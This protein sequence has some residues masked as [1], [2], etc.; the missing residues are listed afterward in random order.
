[1]SIGGSYFARILTYVLCGAPVAGALPLANDF[2]LWTGR[3]GD[4]PAGLTFVCVATLLGAAIVE[5][6]Q[7]LVA[8]AYTPVQSRAVRRRIE[9]EIDQLKAE[10]RPG[11]R[12]EPTSDSSWSD[13]HL[14]HIQLPSSFRTVLSLACCL[15]EAWE[16]VT[17][18][19]TRIAS[20]I[21]LH[22]L[23]VGAVVS[24]LAASALVGHGNLGFWAPVA[25]SIAFA[26]SFLMFGRVVTTYRITPRKPTGRTDLALLSERALDDFL[27]AKL[28]GLNAG[29]SDRVRSLEI[30]MGRFFADHQALVSHYMKVTEE[31]A[32]RIEALGLKVLR[33][34]DAGG[35]ASRTMAKLRAELAE[36]RE[37]SARV[38]RADELG[39]KALYEVS[40]LQRKTARISST[41]A[42]PTAASTEVSIDSPTDGHEARAGVDVLVYATGT[43]PGKPE[44]RALS[45]ALKKWLAE[46][47]VTIQLPGQESEGSFFGRWIARITGVYTKEELDRRLQQGFENLLSAAQ[48]SKVE[49]PMSEN[50][51]ALSQALGNVTAAVG[52]AHHCVVMVNNVLFVRTTRRNGEVLAVAKTL[53]PQMKAA[54]DKDP[55]LVKSIEK[56]LHALELTRE[57]AERSYA[58]ENEQRPGQSA[59]RRTTADVNARRVPVSQH[60]ALDAQP[61]GPSKGRAVDAKTSTQRRTENE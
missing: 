38:S 9:R 55:D 7:V 43:E 5:S 31:L 2:T 27:S 40:E 12:R 28:K 21:M 32:S 44:A 16:R 39:R 14:R 33:A 34:Q 4:L 60:Q 51:L 6:V 17:V 45:D 46:Y 10:P 36:L 58:T 11:T 8:L 53:T 56:L 61:E 54:I 42:T 29:N 52:D 30:H 18:D 26:V 59:E 25:L 57:P 13:E 23:L 1:M 24:L 48:Q 3:G 20:A 47:G 50:S 15:G 19:A 37:L 22:R 35:E 49:K 41:Q